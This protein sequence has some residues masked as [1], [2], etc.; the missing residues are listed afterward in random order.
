LL[1]VWPSAPSFY[2]NFQLLPVSSLQV[3]QAENDPPVISW[4]HGD[5]SIAGYHL[6]LGSSTDGV[7]L[8]DSLINGLAYTDIGWSG[9]T[10]Q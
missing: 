4:T 8:D 3:E 7:R 5:G 1:C 2:L 9:D 6:Y 10:R